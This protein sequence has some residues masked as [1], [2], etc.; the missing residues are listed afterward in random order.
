MEGMGVARG[1]TVP[2]DPWTCKQIKKATTTRAQTKEWIDQEPTNP[3]GRSI[4]ESDAGGRVGDSTPPPA[5]TARPARAR[6]RA[7]RSPI[8]DRHCPIDGRA[9]TPAR[10]RE[11]R[12]ETHGFLQP[13][14]CPRH[15]LDDGWIAWVCWMRARARLSASPFESAS[16]SVMI[17]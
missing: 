4:P 7:T 17:N 9:P 12:T 6:R 14:G 3:S 16:I 10:G 1:C 5:G 13:A 11:G 8:A 2:C 15:G